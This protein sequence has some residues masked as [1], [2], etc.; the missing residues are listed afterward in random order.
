MRV[1]N[2]KIWPYQITLPANLIGNVDLRE[3]WLAENMYEGYPKRWHI[4]GYKPLTYCF[5]DEQDYLIFILRWQ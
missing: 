5:S 1:L 2:K 3:R 4:T